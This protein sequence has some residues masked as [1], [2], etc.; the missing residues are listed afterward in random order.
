MRLLPA[1]LAFIFVAKEYLNSAESKNGFV[2]LGPGGRDVVHRAR[3]SERMLI[4]SFPAFH[5]QH[6]SAL[7]WVLAFIIFLL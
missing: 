7:W 3:N 2:V 6:I 1:H 5:P 4:S